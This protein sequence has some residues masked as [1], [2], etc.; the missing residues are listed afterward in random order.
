MIRD[1]QSCEDQRTFQ[2]EETTTAE[3]VRWEPTAGTISGSVRLFNKYELTAVTA[4][5]PISRAHGG[6][7]NSGY[8]SLGREG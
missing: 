8:S 7:T 4:N 2:A 6:V 5:R 1:N 3:T